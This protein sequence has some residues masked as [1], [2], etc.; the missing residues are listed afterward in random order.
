MSNNYDQWAGRDSI[1]RNKLSN[2]RNSPGQPQPAARPPALTNEAYLNQLTSEK[3]AVA[4]PQQRQS[5]DELERLALI[6]PVTELYNLRW[7]MKTLGYEMK[8]GERYKR[9]LSIAIISIDGLANV[10]RQNGADTADFL[11][12]TA[13]T[14]LRSCVRDVDIAARHPDY[15]FIVLFPETS[16]SGIT[17]VVERIRTRMRSQPVMFAMQNFTMTA[18]IGA[19]TFPNHGRKPEEII[20]RCTQSLQVAIERGGDRVCIL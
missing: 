8:R 14:I 9:Y 7:F 16:A 20:A 6:E 3:A 2:L 1:F 5:L 4:T 11:I 19:A 18:S 10:R 12:K 15:G 13:T 17:T